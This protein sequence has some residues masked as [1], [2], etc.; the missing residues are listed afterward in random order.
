MFI[1]NLTIKVNNAIVHEWMK[2]Q[3]EEHIPEIMATDLFTDYKFYKLLDQDDTE[4]QTFVLQYYSATKGNCDNYI[5]K[6]AP[7]LRE[8]AF[9]KW[10]DGFIIFRTLMQSVQ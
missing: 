5:K 1:Y 6:F 4:G 10:G 2:W 3:M 9:K 8:K 7:Q